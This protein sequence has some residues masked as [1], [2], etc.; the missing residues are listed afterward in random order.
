MLKLDV[1][2]YN[3]G[4]FPAVQEELYNFLKKFNIIVDAGLNYCSYRE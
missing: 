4:L 3:R 2:L 1:Y